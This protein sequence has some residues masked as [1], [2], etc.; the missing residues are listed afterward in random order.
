[1]LVAVVCHTG[2]TA[3]QGP[4]DPASGPAV[5]QEKRGVEDAD[6]KELSSVRPPIERALRGIQRRAAGDRTLKHLADEPIFPAEYGND[7]KGEPKGYRRAIGSPTDDQIE[8]PTKGDA[9]SI[10]LPG[11]VSVHIEVLRQGFDLDVLSGLHN[12]VVTWRTN[13]P[14][15]FVALSWCTKDSDAPDRLL[16]IVREELEREGLRLLPKPRPDWPAATTSERLAQL[17]PPDGVPPVAP[18]PRTGV[19]SPGGP[20][21]GF[22]SPYDVVAAHNQAVAKRDWRAYARRLTPASQGAVIRQVFFL[23]ATVGRTCPELIEAIEKHLKFKLIDASNFPGEFVQSKDAREIFESLG[24]QPGED[25]EAADARL[26]EVIR[27]RVGDV[28]AFLDD[29]FR[30]FQ[31]S[32][33]GYGE[34]IECEG[35]RIEGDR[36]SGYRIVRRPVPDSKVAERRHVSNYLPDYVPIHFRRIGGRWLMKPKLVHIYF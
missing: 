18:P 4:D 14:H 23:A 36:A 9:A 2:A 31:A 16:A 35:I 6:G 22:A 10:R 8:I 25:A 17:L 3:A 21:R 33:E 7:A 11:Y 15:V 5:K 32:P 30:E 12:G 13:N 19:A 1:M 27:K 26:Y 20:A 34:P 28:P 29:C 24:E